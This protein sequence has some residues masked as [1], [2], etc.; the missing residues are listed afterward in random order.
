MRYN[1]IAIVLLFIVSKATAQRVFD[2]V[3]VQAYVDNNKNEW[4]RQRDLNNGQVRMLVVQEIAKDKTEEFKTK[5]T[6]IH[7][8]FQNTMA[9]LS[10]IV[11]VS[12]FATITRDIIKNEGIL[13]NL[14]YKHPYYAPIVIEA[15]FDLSRQATRMVEMITAFV[16]VGSDFTQMNAADRRT[17]LKY[18]LNRFRMIN[19]T[20]EGLIRVVEITISIEKPKNSLFGDYVNI[21]QKIFKEINKQVPIKF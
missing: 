15:H 2:P 11:S 13:L 12:E 20:I 5:V 8:R 17:I 16:M 3:Q 6:Q 7:Q 1:I 14:S 19:S 18:A 10:D 9:V 4:D 21:D